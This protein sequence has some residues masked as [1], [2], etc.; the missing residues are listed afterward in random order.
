MLEYIQKE[1]L[2]VTNP[3]S[4]RQLYCFHSNSYTWQAARLLLQ[5]FKVE[6][7]KGE[8]GV[9]GW[10]GEKQVKKRYLC[11]SKLVWVLHHF[12]SWVIP[13]TP[14]Y[15][16]K[17]KPYVGRVQGAQLYF[18]KCMRNETGSSCSPDR[19]GTKLE[20]SLT[21]KGNWF[22]ESQS[23]GVQSNYFGLF[24][25]AISLGIVQSLLEAVSATLWPL[26][27]VSPKKSS[28]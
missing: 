25:T 21:W 9:G 26:L 27:P 17:R 1:A 13:N 7:E 18:L 6:V 8:A 4:L 22:R 5:P 28:S 10:V 15:T 14:T 3:D 2:G 11:F 19:E 24:F 12:W 16:Q 20:D 23:Y